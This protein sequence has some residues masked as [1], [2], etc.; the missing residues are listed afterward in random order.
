MIRG[1]VIFFLALALGALTVVGQDGNAEAD[2]RRRIRAL[3]EELKRRADTRVGGKAAVLRPVSRIYEI[4]DLLMYTSDRVGEAVDL[5]PSKFK[6]TEQP[7]HEPR[8]PFAI[9]WMIDAIRQ[10]I[11]PESWET[12]EGADIQPRSGRL[13]VH[14]IPRVHTK[15]AA[16]L[17]TLR[18]IADRQLRVEFFAVPMEAGD[19]S[20]VSNRPRELTKEEAARLLN[21]E[22]LGSVET[23]CQSSQHLSQRVGRRLGYLQDYEVEIAQEAHIGDPNRWEVFSG[24]AVE[25]RAMLD[26]SGSGARLDV[27]IDRTKV[28]EPVRRVDTEHGPLELPVLSLTRVRTSAWLPLGKISIIG[29][30][31]AGEKPCLFLGRVSR[32]GK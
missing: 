12:I 31:T 5:M 32:I 26:E 10:V 8:S 28:Q 15:V 9:D 2:L 3:T 16:L 11:E 17:G 30:S 6:A 27:Q 24:M 21:R 4:G 7:E 1:A 25:L 29:G 14:T 20:L 19:A 22:L 13:F 18:G 23:V